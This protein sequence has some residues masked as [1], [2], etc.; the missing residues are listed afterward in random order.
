MQK[1]HVACVDPATGQSRAA[2]NLRVYLA[3]TFNL[4]TLYADDEVT[5]LPNPLLSDSAGRVAFKVQDGEYDIEVS[6]S[7]FETYKITLVQAMDKDGYVTS[8][9]MADVVRSVEKLRADLDAL[10]AK[11]EPARSK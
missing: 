10:I 1:L 9:A 2:A 7:G 3:W 5:L 6:G 11:N 8:T 4:A